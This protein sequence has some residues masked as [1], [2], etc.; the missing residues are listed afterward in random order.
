M[1]GPHSQCCEGKPRGDGESCQ[2]A[3]T[4]WSAGAWAD[5]EEGEG[6]TRRG[7]LC[8]GRVEEA[9]G[10]MA[11]SV[12]PV[13]AE[14]GWLREGTGASWVWAQDGALSWSG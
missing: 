1:E 8:R 14:Q 11:P 5:G 13:Q 6:R 10:S 2:E 7:P 3:G 4:L 12:V 9:S